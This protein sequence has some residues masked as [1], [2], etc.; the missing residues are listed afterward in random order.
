MAEHESIAERSRES[1]ME[2]ESLYQD[3]AELYDRLYTFKDYD[4]EAERLHTLLQGE[5]VADGARVFEA[6]CD[7]GLSQELPA[8]ARGAAILS[9]GLYGDL[10]TDGALAREVD[11]PHAALPQRGS[12]AEFTITLPGRG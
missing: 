10:T 9:D 3:R 5:G 8:R 6:A 7:P 4:G 2:Y 12:D 1:A 11:D